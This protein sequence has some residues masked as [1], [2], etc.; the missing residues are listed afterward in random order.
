MLRAEYVIAVEM[1]IIIKTPPIIPARPR[2][3]FKMSCHLSQVS[4]TITFPKTIEK[5]NVSP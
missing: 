1:I 3:F 5:P 2:L 4:S